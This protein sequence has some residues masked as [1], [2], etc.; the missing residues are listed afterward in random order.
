MKRTTREWPRA[1][2][3]RGVACWT[4]LLALWTTAGPADADQVE[5][6]NGDHF[7]GRV[8]SLNA[9]TLVLQSDILGTLKLPRAKVALITLG[10]SPTA[11]ASPG[12]SGN[13]PSRLS[14]QTNSPSGA[15]LV[16]STN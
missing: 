2:W 13:R 15:P 16:A 5:L 3:A 12:G 8:V 10:T 7:V 11:G 9:E 4:V 6:Q 1:S 14:S